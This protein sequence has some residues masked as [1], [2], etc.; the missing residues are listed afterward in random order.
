MTD[1]RRTW[2]F[3]CDTLDE[4]NE[5]LSAFNDSIA[6]ANGQLEAAATINTNSNTNSG[7]RGAGNTSTNKKSDT[8]PGVNKGSGA[9]KEV[10]PNSSNIKVQK[11]SKFW[12]IN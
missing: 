10:S 6:L 7:Y 9:T 8:P 11:G 4:M 3:K 1:E 12:N 5:W 2:D